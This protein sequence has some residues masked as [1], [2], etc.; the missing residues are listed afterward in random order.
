MDIIIETPKGSNLK[1]KW[2]E[3]LQQFRVKKKLAAGLAFPFD[4][5]FI[6]GTKGEDGDP[7]DVLVIAEFSTFPGCR[8]DCRLIG[9]IQA[10]QGANGA[11]IRNDRYL[12]VPTVSD[13][14]HSL[15]SIE[16]IPAEML[17]GIE[18]FIVHYISAEGKKINLPGRLGAQQ[19]F[20][21]VRSSTG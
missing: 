11:M 9:C 15:R 13:W 1:Y 4:F 12:A 14:S 6:P 19:A 3:D 18:Q 20:E 7:L 17:S 10:R 5:G 21:L 16:D 8:V 2:V